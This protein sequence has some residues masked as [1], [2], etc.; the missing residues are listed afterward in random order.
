MP[1]FLKRLLVFL[2]LFSTSLADGITSA[3]GG[4]KFSPGVLSASFTI[5]ADITLNIEPDAAQEAI[6]STAIDLDS[7]PNEN[8]RL[9]Q[10]ALPFTGS[11]NL[12]VTFSPKD[13]TL[14]VTRT[15]YVYT[16]TQ[17]VPVSTVPEPETYGMML[18]GLSL[19]VLLARN[20]P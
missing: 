7:P 9:G 8:T 11:D 4:V 3:S 13:E 16:N 19:I 15:S 6:T 1:K 10:L 2:I 12:L 14:N 5:P 20:K 17:V 18:A